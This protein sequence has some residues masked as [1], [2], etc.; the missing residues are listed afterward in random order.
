[1]RQGL[2]K[3]ACERATRTREQEAKEEFC[4]RPRESSFQ[5]EHGQDNQN[6]EHAAFTNLPEAT[7]RRRPWCSGLPKGENSQPE[8]GGGGTLLQGHRRG[9]CQESESLGQPTGHVTTHLIDGA[10][11]WSVFSWL[12]GCRG[13]LLLGSGLLLRQKDSN[14]MVTQVA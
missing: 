14:R 8:V 5:R 10:G 2:Y 6:T 9:G 13:R 7:G 1:M 11:G 3:A 4:L 12:R